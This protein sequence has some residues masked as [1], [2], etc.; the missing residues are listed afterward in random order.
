M[1]LNKL[2]NDFV[3]K[4][5]EI[6]AGNLSSEILEKFFTLA[7]GE[8]KNHYFTHSSESNLLRIIQSTFEKISFL[9]NC[10]KYPHYIEI[11][12]S[13]SVNSNYLADILVINPEYFYW[14]VNSSVLNNKL[15]PKSFLQEVKESTRHYNS[16]NSKVRTLKSIKRKEL[17]RI[18]LKDIYNKTE[19]VE[20][21]EELSI[22]ASTLISEL[23]NICYEKTLAKNKIEKTSR[24]YCIVSLGK[25]GGNELN[26]SSDTDLIVFYDKES[27]LSSK[28]FYSEI[29]TETIHLFLQTAASTEG[30]H[31]YRIDLRLR[32][33]GRNSPLCRSLNEY[34]NYYES[35]G[36]DWERQMLIKANFLGGH[37]KLFDQFVSYLS[38]FIYPTSSYSSPLEHIKKLKSVV[39]RKLGDEENIKLIPGGIRDIEFS[40]QALQLMYG[41]KYKNIQ[42]GNTIAALNQLEKVTLLTNKEKKT[43]ESAYI[44]YRKTEH[45]LQ[46]MNNAQTHIVP[47]NGE[48]TEKLSIYLHFESFSKFKTTLNDQQTCVRKIYNT[49]VSGNGGKKSVNTKIP[50]VN[51]KD[52]LRASKNLIYLREGKGLLGVRRFDKKTFEAFKKIEIQLLKYLNK[53]SFPDKL[54]DNFVRIIRFAE[55]PSIWYKELNDKQFLKILLSICEFSQRSIDLFA[56][57]KELRDYFLNREFLKIYS[58]RQLSVFSIKKIFFILST[59]CVLGLISPLKTSKMLSETV[60]NKLKV[61]SNSFLQNYKWKHDLFIAALGSTGSGE[62]VFNSD[63]DLIF[64]AKNIN[65]FKKIEKDFQDYLYILQTELKPISVDCRLR[66]EGKSSQLVW[67]IEEYKKYFNTRARTWEFQSLIKSSF[68]N[69]NKNLY[70]EFNGAIKTALYSKDKT[71]IKNDIVEM[72]KKLSYSSTSQLQVIDLKE[73]CGW[74]SG[75]RVCYIFYYSY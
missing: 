39:E 57:D 6:S 59:Q 21:T 38:P 65:R 35:R 24:K 5:E 42:T 14:V 62:M 41:G 37:S 51:F 19:L 9:Q 11:L 22:L 45:Y 53:S 61:I 64:A 43:F 55:F 17:L 31:L 28:K 23:F 33:D 69:G 58:A 48:I 12:V 4:I 25:L 36:E 7:E 32:P 71:V 3:K 70:N 44:L 74:F 27:K 29:L 15:E 52:P 67:D 49:V 20:I 54:L 2:S 46:L 73:R 8:I 50:E 1:R 72:R 16:F 30:G 34:L 26:Y 60:K 68:I 56:E 75:Y 63:I 66:P 47:Q 13:I 40:V 10:V 18:G